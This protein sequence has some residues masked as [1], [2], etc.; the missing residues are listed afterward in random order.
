MMPRQSIRPGILGLL[1]LVGSAAAEERPATRSPKPPAGP[2]RAPPVDVRA[3][4]DPKAAATAAQVLESAY[5][6]QRPPEAVRM[7]AAILRGSQMGAG[8]GWFGP[9]EGRYSW[10]WLARRCGVDSAQ[11]SIP[12][13]KFPGSDALFRRLDRNQDGA[14]TP[15]DFDWSD[16]NPYV[17]MA[18]MTSRLFRKLNTQSNGRL[19]KEE[20]LRF[21]EKSAQGKDYL[22]TDDFRDGLLA[23]LFGGYKPGDAPQPAVL[24]R[25][26]FSGEL[27]SMN[28]GPALNDLAPDFTLRTSDGKS[29]VQLAKLLGKK[30]VVLVFGSF[31]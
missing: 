3:I 27:G 28:E 24:L 1:L 11:R 31:T 23:G 18:A 29:T 26:L 15:D 17:Q 7:M 8:E 30:P 12:R 6:G 9:A 2:G 13:S 25:G 19:T 20:L 4:E 5:A 21:F 10:Q 14:I 16:R 22:S